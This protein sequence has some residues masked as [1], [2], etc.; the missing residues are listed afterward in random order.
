MKVGYYPGCCMTNS[1]PEYGESLEAVAPLLGVELDELRDWNCCGASSAHA[2]DELLGVAL[3]ARNLALAEQQGLGELMAPC[4]ACY[5]RL[6]VARDAVT[7]DP[8]MAARVRE[9][10]ARP[11]HGSLPVV[12]VVELFDGL[13]G[14][15]ETRRTRPLT[16]LRL[17]C[18]YGCLL[19][20]PPKVVRFD[21][22]E[23]PESMQRVV[24]A[25]GAE[26]VD[27]PMALECCGAGFSLARTDSVLRLSRGILASARAAGADAV[28]TAC[29]MCHSNL[30][31]RQEAMTR[32]GERPMPILFITQAVGLTFDLDAA[33]LGFRRHFVSTQPVAERLAALAA[34]GDAAGDV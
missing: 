27:W 4:A 10:L 9:V 16:G 15:I 24:A 30:D 21:D 13:T 33:A 19:V 22:P 34:G 12:N 7:S 2:T 14:E 17:A 20:R 18:Y 31:F 23:R 25:C 11:L 32:R 5:N 26:P 29:P 6:A 1:S 28:V 8:S 3:A